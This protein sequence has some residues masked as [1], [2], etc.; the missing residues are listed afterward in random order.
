MGGASG[1]QYIIEEQLKPSDVSDIPDGDWKAAKLEVE[2]LRQLIAQVDCNILDDIEEMEMKRTPVKRSQPVISSGYSYDASDGSLIA[3]PVTATISKQETIDVKQMMSLLEE[4]R[5]KILETTNNLQAAFSQIDIDYSGYISRDEFRVAMSSLGLEMTDEEFD[6]VN[7]TYPHKE[8]IGE[9]DKGIGYLEFV[10][11]LTGALTYIPGAGE[12]ETV[13]D[14]VFRMTLK[15]DFAGDLN[16][17]RGIEQISQSLSETGQL[18]GLYDDA[19]QKRNQE[20]Q[21]QKM[22]NRRMFDSLYNLKD[23]FLKADK[24]SSGFIEMSELKE[25]LK[26]TMGIY[27]SDDQIDQL[28]TEFDLNRDGKL[29]YNEF[30]KCLQNE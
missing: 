10:S 23:A 21:L 25:V 2:R 15:G 26:D 29:A 9:I 28:M 1:R 20:V 3:P 7:K 5:A 30:V 16:R 18:W 19:K 6:L 11:M 24:D 14:E 12:Q 17:Q 27:A 22:F 13:E 4:I 8:G